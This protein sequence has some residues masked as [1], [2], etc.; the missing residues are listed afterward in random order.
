MITERSV[1]QTKRNRL[2]APFRYYLGM[3]DPAERRKPGRPPA[4]AAGAH[5]RV[6]DAVYEL[7]QERPARELT[8][9]MVAKRAGVG[10][11]TLYKWWPSR[12]ALMLAMFRERVHA[13][14][15][16]VETGTAEEV[17]RKRV[18]RL[19]REFNGLF[20]K[21]MAGL[22]AEGQGDPAVLDDL[23]TR[24][25][26]PSRL[27]TIREIERGKAAGEFAPDADAALVVDAIIAPLYFR[28]LLRNAPITDEYGE[29]LVDHALRS[30]RVAP[31]A[32]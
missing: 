13:T 24:H 16:P 22:I 32:R 15:E 14:R 9:E 7:L 3:I 29:D 18:Q 5:A 30:V 23:Y 19:V 26:L 1:N 20:G 28:L 11:P 25:M 21:V 4:E 27:E 17:I 10:K 6:M 2:Y 8:M 12:A 31:E